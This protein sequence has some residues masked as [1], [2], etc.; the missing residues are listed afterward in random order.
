MASPQQKTRTG[1]RIS[2]VLRNGGEIL[3]FNVARCVVDLVSLSLLHGR[4]V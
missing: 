4:E 1:I 3:D 2:R